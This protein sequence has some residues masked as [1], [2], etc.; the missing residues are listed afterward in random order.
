MIPVLALA[1]LALAA[2]AVFGWRRRLR[3]GLVAGILALAMLVN[4]LLPAGHPLRGMTGGEAAPWGLLLAG[5]AIVAGYAAVL[6]RLRARAQPPVPAAATA[7]TPAPA[8]VTPPAFTDDDLTRY[9]R[10]IFL[11]E[12]GGPGQKRLKAARVLVIGAGGLGAPALMY[13]AAAGVGT[14]GIV[15]DDAVDLSNLQRQVVHTTDRI[16]QPKVASAAAALR[17]LNPGVTVIPHP[18]RL[19]EGNADSLVADYDLILD[20]T[21]SFAARYAANAAA[22][23]AGKPLVGGALTQWEGQLSV[24]HPAGGAPCYACVFPEPPAPGLV[25]TCAEAGVL[26]PL[27]GIIGTMMAAEAVKIVTGAG[28]P[29]RGRLLIWDALYA[30]ARIIAVNRRAGCAVCGG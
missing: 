14:I 2:G 16:G 24:W 21:D 9:A 22:V 4:L 26:G 5:G 30:D 13:L 28:E 10:H 3:W 19:T 6:R 8:P 7:P 1:A 17:A 25:P 18:V 11:R 20:G 27:P 29:L 12:I 23:R 15:D